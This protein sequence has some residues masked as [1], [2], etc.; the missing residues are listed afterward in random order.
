[1]PPTADSSSPEMVLQPNEMMDAV[2]P[3]AAEC[4]ER[5]SAACMELRLEDIDKSLEETS[6]LL[7]ALLSALR[8]APVQKAPSA[9]TQ[10][11]SVATA[12]IRWVRVR[13]V[14]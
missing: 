2:L 3:Q 13:P 12:E 5:A 9:E 7:D 1:M 8:T 6:A 14:A 4:L 10:R 11:K